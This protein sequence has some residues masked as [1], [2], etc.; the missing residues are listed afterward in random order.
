LETGLF[1]SFSCF[2]SYSVRYLFHLWKK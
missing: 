1:F 2:S